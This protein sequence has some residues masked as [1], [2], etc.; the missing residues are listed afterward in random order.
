LKKFFENRWIKNKIAVYISIEF[1]LFEI[2]TESIISH[3]NRNT[4][5]FLRENDRMVV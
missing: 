2:W 3:I 5:F 4:F 1:N